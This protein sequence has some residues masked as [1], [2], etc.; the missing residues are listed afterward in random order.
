M[1]APMQKLNINEA[2]A[3][4]TTVPALGVFA[5]VKTASGRSIVGE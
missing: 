2:T 3:R 4:P 1:P 5:S